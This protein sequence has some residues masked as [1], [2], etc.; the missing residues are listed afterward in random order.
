[1]PD[2]NYRELYKAHLAENQ[3]LVYF[4]L[5]A[6]GAAI[7]LALNQTQ[8][9]PIVWSQIPLALA[10]ICWGLS[11]FFG[12]R[13]LQYRLSNL[14]A[15]LTLLEVQSGQYQESGNNP[16]LIDAM[17]NGIREAMKFNEKRA[18]IF[19]FLHYRLLILGAILYIAWHIL[20][21]YLRTVTPH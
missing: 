16:Q 7:G 8:S 6:D 9:A 19:F 3:R 21:M 5:A 18:S 11:F 10:V 4:L 12:I 13:Y 14:Y 15:N 2:E 20:E 1:M 17:S